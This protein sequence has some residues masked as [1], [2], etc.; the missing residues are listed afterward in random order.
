MK[1]SNKTCSSSSTSIISSGKGLLGL[2]HD[3][4]AIV[5]ALCIINIL[6]GK[7]HTD[8]A[9]VGAGGPIDVVCLRH[10]RQAR[11]LFSVPGFQSIA[12]CYPQL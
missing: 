9:L 11:Y 8:T 12:N 5:P 3:S 2:L 6:E 4:P 7:S 1:K 10:F